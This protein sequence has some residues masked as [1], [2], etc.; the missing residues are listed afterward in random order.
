[1]PRIIQT[2]PDGSSI[3]NYLTQSA[4]GRPFQTGAIRTLPNGMLF[5]YSGPVSYDIS[6][7]ATYNMMDFQL[8]NTALLRFNFSGLFTALQVANQAFGYRIIVDG[9]TVYNYS[10]DTRAEAYGGSPQALDIQIIAPANKTVEVL[11]L[12]PDA[13]A[14]LIEAT[15]IVIGEQI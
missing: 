11:L 1:M 5:G 6:A 4:R 2:N 12:N 13:S 8:E 9:I 3:S 7:S 14:N 10:S 15:C